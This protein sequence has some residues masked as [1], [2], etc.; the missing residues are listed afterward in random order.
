MSISMQGWLMAASRRV[1]CSSSARRLAASAPGRSV[2]RRFTATFWP[3]RMP[4]NTSANAPGAM[5]RPSWMSSG[6]SLRAPT[7]EVIFV[8][9]IVLPRSDTP[10]AEAA[11]A[12]RLAAAIASA[13]TAPASTATAAGSAA[14]GAV[15]AGAE[16]AGAVAAGAV[17]AGAVAAG[18]V[19]AAAAGAAVGDDAGPELAGAVAPASAFAFA[20]A[21]AFAFASTSSFAFTSASSFTFASASALAFASSASLA[22]LIAA[23]TASA[24][25]L[26]FSLSR[27]SRS[28]LAAFPRARL[29][30]DGRCHAQRL[31]PCQPLSQL[32]LALSLLPGRIGS[33]RGGSARGIRLGLLLQLQPPPLAQFASRLHA[34][35]DGFV[36]HPLARAPAREPPPLNLG[37]GKLGEQGVLLLAQ[38]RSTRKLR[39]PLRRD[40]VSHRAE[41]RAVRL[42]LSG[43]ELDKALLLGQLGRE[44][45]LGLR[46]GLGPFGSRR[47]GQPRIRCVRER[48]SQIECKAMQSLLAQPRCSRPSTADRSWHRPTHTAEGEYGR[49]IGVEQSLFLSQADILLDDRRLPLGRQAR[50]SFCLWLNPTPTS[51]GRRTEGVKAVFELCNGRIFSFSF[52]FQRLFTRKCLR[53]A[54]ARR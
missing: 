30:P 44:W 13:E 14:A 26:S 2:K 5:E 43:N 15:A 41:A 21:S 46:G 36:L 20:S 24:S 52:P 38:R 18:A 17:A 32:A 39:V 51:Q 9:R 28:P 47:E 54:Q 42:I 40:A 7:L 12:K 34:R 22:A 35:P 11:V 31:Q 45:T 8:P 19:A 16:A 3:H 53:L 29:N 27:R 6:L 4:R 50:H 10:E 33:R 1:S 25:S 48:R 23:A 37:S 49:V